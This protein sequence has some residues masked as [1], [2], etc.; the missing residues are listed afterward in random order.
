[1]SGLKNAVEPIAAD[2]NLGQLKGDCTGVMHNPRTNIASQCMELQAHLVLRHALAGQSGPVDLLLAFL[3]VLLGGAALVV[4]ADDPVRFH[5]H[6]G[7]HEAHAREQLA[8]MPFHLGDDPTGLVPGCRL[9]LEVAVDALNAFWR[10]SHRPLE[11]IRDFA[12]KNA[13]GA[14][15]CQ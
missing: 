15:A 13:V 6:V 5:R 2:S 8:G 14:Q 1:M 7:D 12:L 11:Q 4:E 10:I 3:D 9:I